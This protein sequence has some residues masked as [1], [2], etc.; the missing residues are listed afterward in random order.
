[1]PEFTDHGPAPYVLDIE[2]ATTSNDKFRTTIWTG[3]RLQATLMSIPPGG[4]IGLEVHPENDQFLRLEQGKGRCQ[5]GPAEDDLPFDEIVEDDWAIFVPAGTWHNVTNVGDEPM[6]LYAIY[7]PPD[8]EPGTVH[9]TQ[10]DAENDP[11]EH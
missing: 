5:M 10:E 4:D 8:H 1:M 3:T 7:G 11:H 6:R 9:D 2:D